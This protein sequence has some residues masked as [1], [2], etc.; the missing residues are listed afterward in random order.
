MKIYIK[1]MVCPGTRSFVIEELEGLGLNYNT[2]ESGGIDFK[3]NLSQAERNKLNKSMQQYGLELSFGKSN[4]ISKIL[5]VI[6][7]LADNHTATR[8]KIS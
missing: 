2:F 7:N 8:Q 6:H 5:N 1:N 4:M 3:E